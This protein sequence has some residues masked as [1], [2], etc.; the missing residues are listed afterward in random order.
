MQIKIVGNAMVIT[1]GISMED[2][3]KIYSYTP[4]SLQMVDEE[5]NTTFAIAVGT[6]A[7][8]SN[9]GVVFNSSNNQGKAIA[10]IMLPNVE[11]EDKTNYVL[12]KYG[13]GLLRLQDLEAQ[14][15]EAVEQMKKEFTAVRNT[16]VVE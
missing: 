2:L 13:K 7:S 6:N 5:G 8:F 9:A 1:S 4:E 11:E 3:Q 12:N 15:N 14:L 16:I 10:T